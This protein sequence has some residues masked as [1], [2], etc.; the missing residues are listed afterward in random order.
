MVE[1]IHPTDSNRIL[2]RTVYLDHFATTPVDPTVFT[3]MKPYL[4]E[5]FGNPGTTTNHLGKSAHVAVESARSAIRRY[6]GGASESAVL[7]TSGTTESNNLLLRGLFECTTNR[8]KHIVTTAIEHQAVL[9][10]CRW[11]ERH[12]F[13]VTYVGVQS[14]GRVDPND[15]LQAIRSDT[16]LVSVMFVNNETGVIQPIAEIARDTHSRGILFHTDASQGLGK[17]EFDFGAAKVDFVSFSAHKIYGPK[18]VGGLW[19]RSIDAF[20]SLQSQLLGGNQEWG[21]RAGTHNVPGIVGLRNCFEQ[22]ETYGEQERSRIRNLRDRLYTQLTS[23]LEGIT[24]N[25][26]FSSLVP[27]ALNISIDGI[28]SADVLAE[29][30]EI[31][32]SSVAACGGKNGLS[33]VLSAMGLPRPKIHSVIRFGM[34]RFNTEEEI[35]YAADRIIGVVKRIRERG[36]SKITT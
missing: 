12:G 30:P 27:N 35:D 31:A 13:E 34:G 16:V 11:L 23:N 15:V 10:P 14:N 9:E 36:G 26:E 7:F 2:S 33:H 6:M 8:G 3:A 18:G 20:E 29:L 1:L 19:V 5:Q 4:T 25:G 32:L 21:L 22:F 24:V 17:T 28:K